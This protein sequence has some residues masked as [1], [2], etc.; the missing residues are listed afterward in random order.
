MRP[1]AERGSR[2]SSRILGDTHPGQQRQL[3]EDGADAAARRARRARKP[4]RAALEQDAAG[5]RGEPPAEYLDER[6]FPRPVLA[7]ERVHLAGARGERGGAQRL[8]AAE[9]LA[10]PARGDRSGRLPLRRRRP[11]H[12]VGGSRMSRLPAQGLPVSA[13]STQIFTV[14]SGPLSVKSAKKLSGRSG[15]TV[16]PTFTVAFVT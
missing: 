9:R 13:A 15:N 12:A 11:A 8:H 1:K 7:D 14:A 10:R 4:H 16:S 5:V 6:R 2:P 3:L